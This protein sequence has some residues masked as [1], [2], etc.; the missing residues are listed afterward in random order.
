MPR[1]KGSATEISVKLTPAQ[2]RAL[3][4]LLP[5]RAG[6]L[7]LDGTTAKAFLFKR[8]EADAVLAKAAKDGPGN[9]TARRNLAAAFQKVID[10]AGPEAAG[11]E[12]SAD[13]ADGGGSREGMVYRLKITLMDSHP[14]IW[15]RI[16]VEDGNL[17]ELHDHIQ[18]S[19]GWTNSHLHHF[20]IG[21][22]LYG[23]PLL[24]SDN[25]FDLGYKDSLTT[26]LGGITPKKG[27]KFRFEY[28]YDFGDSWLHEI[29]VEEVAPAD[30][31]VKYPV[32]T[33]GKRA[34]PPEDVGGVWGYDEFLA[35]IADPK[36]DR[37]E[38]FMEWYEGGF[39]PDAFDPDEAT[40]RMK[41]NAVE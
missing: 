22:D 34:C 38:E 28:E 26:T 21:K 39:E 24:M 41:E 6:D 31:A 11:A 7:E 20:V 18:A 19:M 14:T 35:A 25:F 13:G 1:D 5:K 2:R 10:E 37:H 33:G 12:A 3:A 30:P 27:K 29:E 16:V 9:P 32:C 17:D 36:H 4:E 40:R 23:D 15:R 8:K